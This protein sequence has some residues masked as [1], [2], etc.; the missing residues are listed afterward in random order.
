MN[1]QTMV[2]NNSTNAL[3]P[4]FWFPPVTTSSVLTLT[5]PHPSVLAVVVYMMESV[6]PVNEWSVN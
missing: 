4:F 1:I 3:I 6:R 5:A 2:P